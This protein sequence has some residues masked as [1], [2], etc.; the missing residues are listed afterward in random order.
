MLVVLPNFS[1]VLIGEFSF[2]ST[3]LITDPTRESMI[4]GL[5]MHHMVGIM[6]GSSVELKHRELAMMFINSI[7]I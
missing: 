1:G 2:H 5:R 7:T 4:Y 6:D 3:E